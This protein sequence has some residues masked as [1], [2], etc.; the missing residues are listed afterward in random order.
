ML[1]IKTFYF[2]LEMFC[3]LLVYT[4]YNNSNIEPAFSRQ[5]NLSI[6]HAF[7]ACTACKQLAVFSNCLGL[8]GI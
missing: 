7:H 1:S 8:D 5:L 4:T 2:H 6:V 3:L